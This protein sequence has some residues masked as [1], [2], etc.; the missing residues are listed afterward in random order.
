MQ[1]CRLSKAVGRV[2]PSAASV[3][4]WS[5]EA[6]ALRGAIPFR[7]VRRWVGRESGRSASLIFHPHRGECNY[8]LIVRMQTISL[9]RDTLST[10][11]H[12]AVEVS[13]PVDE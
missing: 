7:A 4:L 6:D 1:S 2:S 13:A 8:S 3:A 12:C 11:N 9:T 5:S 10:K